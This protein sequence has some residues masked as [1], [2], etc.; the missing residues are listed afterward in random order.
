MA[1]NCPDCYALCH[2][3]GDIDDICFDLEEDV[4]ACAHCPLDADDDDYFDYEEVHSGAAD[5]AK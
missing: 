4:N 3:N 2:C 1:H 5:A